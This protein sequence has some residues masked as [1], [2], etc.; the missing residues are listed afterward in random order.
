MYTDSDRSLAVR[1]SDGTT[2]LSNKQSSLPCYD[3]GWRCY[4]ACGVSSNLQKDNPHQR[5][6]GSF[7]GRL[8][9][10]GMMLLSFAMRLKQAI[11]AGWATEQDIKI[12]DMEL[13]MSLVEKRLV[14]ADPLLWVCLWYLYSVRERFYEGTTFFT[15]K[16]SSDINPLIPRHCLEN[17][18]SFGDFTKGTV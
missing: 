17:T 6:D 12:G 10:Y 5:T 7:N 15:R 9:E 11:L 16:P 3:S 1:W 14:F 2:L 4:Q 8:V 18:Y 13:P